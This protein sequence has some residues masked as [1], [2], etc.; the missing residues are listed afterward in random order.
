[1]K[2]L[3]ILHMMNNYNAIKFLNNLMEITDGRI[4]MKNPAAECAK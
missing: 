4:E 3:L 2:N 1:M